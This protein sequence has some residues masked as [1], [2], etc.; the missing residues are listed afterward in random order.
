MD[1]EKIKNEFFKRF[2]RIDESDVVF[3]KKFVQSLFFN[4]DK[5]LESYLKVKIS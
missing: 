2:L 3:G 4:K 1:I 5:V